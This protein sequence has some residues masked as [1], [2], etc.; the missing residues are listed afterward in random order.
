MAEDS[1]DFVLLLE[2]LQAWENADHLAGLSMNRARL[3]IEQLADFMP[4]LRTRRMCL[5]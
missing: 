1:V 3:C 4:G 2:D 5:R